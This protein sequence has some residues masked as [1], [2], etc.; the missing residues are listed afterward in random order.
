MPEVS[1]GHSPGRGTGGEDPETSLILEVLC[2][3]I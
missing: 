3:L 2:Y 1:S